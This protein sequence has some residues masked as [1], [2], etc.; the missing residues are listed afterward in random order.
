MISTI[1]LTEY[2]FKTMYTLQSNNSDNDLAYEV[3]LLTEGMD[4][5]KS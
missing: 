3:L 2:N 1:I 5:T 4:I